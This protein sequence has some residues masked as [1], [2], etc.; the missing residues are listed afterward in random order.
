MVNDKEMT[1]YIKFGIEATKAVKKNDVNLIKKLMLPENCPAL[2]QEKKQ[3][4]IFTM[5]LSL[6]YT[7][8]I[9]EEFLHFFIF[10]H[11]ASEEIYNK[12]NYKN[13]IF[14]NMFKKRKLKEDLENNLLINEVTKISKKI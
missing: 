14:D 3:D 13:E 4:C 6:F 10:E 11:K 5:A 7:G 9:N 8:A 12:Q 1:D 2:S